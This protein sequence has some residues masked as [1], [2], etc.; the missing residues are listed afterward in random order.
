MYFFGQNVTL[1]LVFYDDLV[2]QMQNDRSQ[3]KPTKAK[4][5]KKQAPPAPAQSTPVK[6]NSIK[7]KAGAKL[8]QGSEYVNEDPNMK[9]DVPVEMQK[10]KQVVSKKIQSKKIVKDL[11]LK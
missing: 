5:N 8:I 1:T 7:K 6:S 10:A 11:N 9:T 4:N 3:P 2:N